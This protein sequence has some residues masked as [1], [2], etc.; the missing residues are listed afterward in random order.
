MTRYFADVFRRVLRAE[1]LLGLRRRL[2]D[3]SL[4]PKLDVTSTRFLRLL[5][6]PLLGLRA[7]QI[8]YR[9]AQTRHNQNMLNTTTH[10]SD[11]PSASLTTSSSSILSLSST[12][13]NP[14]FGTRQSSSPC[15]TKV[16]AHSD[17]QCASERVGARERDLCLGCAMAS[18]LPLWRN[19][20]VSPHGLRVEPKKASFT[21]RKLRDS[22]MFPA[23]SPT[24]WLAFPS[25]PQ[26][27]N[28]K[29]LPVEFL[30]NRRCSA[31]CLDLFNLNSAQFC[32]DASARQPVDETKS[33]EKP[34][35]TEVAC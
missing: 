13:R 24:H 14:F 16:S 5:G 1:S 18:M 32:E 27:I 10:G 26:Q 29:S 3:D 21:A 9:A 30:R 20:R 6:R 23:A 31:F 25:V 35:S 8:C 34:E 17:H 7:H 12:Q 33:S 22:N 28:C 11:S 2:I 19:G 4:H 15:L